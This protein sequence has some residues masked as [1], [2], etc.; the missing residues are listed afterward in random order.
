M[1]GL[2]YIST[3]TRPDIAFAVGNV[4]R[5]SSDPSKAHWQA[6]KRIMRYLQGSQDFGLRYERQK[7]SVFTC[8]GYADA[9]WGGSQDDRKSTSAYVFQANGAAISWRSQKQTCVALSTAEAE[10]VSLSAAAQEAIWLRGLLAEIIGGEEKQ[11]ELLED[12]QSAICMASNPVFHGRTKHVELKY[13]YV[14]DQ[15]S[16]GHICLT[17]CPTERMIADALTK[18]LPANKFVQMREW[19][20]LARHPEKECWR[21]RMLTSDVITEQCN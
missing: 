3:K 20:G 9:D 6:V 18:S 2:L 8:T 4:A 1:G 7:E 16:K 13:H 17:Y 12:N 21:S 5:F 15:V 11:M 14:R 10:Y 19:L